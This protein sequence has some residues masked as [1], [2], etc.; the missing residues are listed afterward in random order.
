MTTNQTPEGSGPFRSPSYQA[1]QILFQAFPLIARVAVVPFAIS[2]AAVVAAQLVGLPVRYGF[3]AVHGLMVISYLTAVT[4]VATGTYPGVN[5]FGLAVPRPRMS[6]WPGLRPVLSMLADAALLIL[7][8]TF[9]LF[10]LAIYIGPF[11]FNIESL[12][13]H[14]AAVL[15]PEFI[16]VTLLGLVI[17]VGLAKI[18]ED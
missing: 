6:A 12:I 15:L 16:L 7:P 8:A 4:R 9:I 1:I 14:V 13:V 17:G 3:D 2:V 18:A 5:A 10:L 11:V